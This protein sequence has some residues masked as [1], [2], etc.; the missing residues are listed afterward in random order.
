MN[1]KYLAFSSILIAGLTFAL[2]V[3]AQTPAPAKQK[4]MENAKTRATQE[5]DRRISTLTNLSNKSANLK[6]VS[7]GAKADISKEVQDEISSL[8]NLKEKIESDSGTTTLKDDVKSITQSYR[9]Y[10]LVVPQG[11][12][13]VA[14]DRIV[15]IGNSL[16]LISAKLKSRVAELQTAGQDV[17]TLQTAI[18]DMDTKIA[19]AL[20]Q[21][22]TAST[23]VASLVPDNG[24]T[25]TMQAN[26]QAL[27][28]AQA[29]IKAGN[30]DLIAA[31]KDAETV[32]KALKISKPKIKEKEE[33]GSTTPEG[34]GGALSQ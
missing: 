6:R 22:Q 20:V 2:P 4:Q 10:A 25:T 31:R 19:D 12:I 15:T 16:S 7:A 3:F 24:A 27:V 21:A 11:H 32:L 18:T 1:K 13:L 34:Q 29:D 9:I 30:Q 33:E 23:S 5:I 26:K 17:T 14:S 8:S 28:A